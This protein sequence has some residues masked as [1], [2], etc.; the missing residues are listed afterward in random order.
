MEEIN[1]R[2]QAISMYLSNHTP[3]EICRSLQRSRPWFYKWLAR[4][5]QDPKGQW[6]IDHPSVPNN[7]L[8][9]YTKE[10]EAIVIQIR[11]RLEDTLYA[12]IG[13]ISIQWEME[14]LNIPPLPIW[15]ID[16]IIKRNGLKK[17]KTHFPKRKNEYPDYSTAHTH[18]LDFVGPRYLKKSGKYYFCNIINTNDHCLNINV[19]K[20]KKA[21]FVTSSIIRFWKQ[22][23]IPDYLQLDNELSFRGSNRY[24]HHFGLLIRFV[25]SLDVRLVFIPQAEPWRNGIIEKFNDTFDKKFF[26]TQEF[27]NCA[28]LVEQTKKFEHF[29]NNNYRYSSQSNRTPIMVHSQE[30]FIQYLDDNYE[31]PEYI[32]LEKGEIIVIR[33]IR[34]NRQLNIFGET[35]LL[36]PELIYNYVEAKICI[37]SQSLKIYL[38]NT[39]VQ[40]FPYYVPVDWM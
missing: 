8:K 40:E 38:D 12:Q 34:S 4:Y 37:E 11:K 33:F 19:N 21:E 14:K 32:P 6:Y 30:K 26:R 16:R 22:F 24:S 13:A 31:L 15:T 1:R 18:Q 23:G 17:E 10:Q 7:V 27:E 35:F 5:Q 25:L 39:L 29:H 9:S 3:S 2:K 20:N 36:N 28:Q